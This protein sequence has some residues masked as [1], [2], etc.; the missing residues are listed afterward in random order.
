[1]QL[2]KALF[3]ILRLGTTLE[4]QGFISALVSDA[5]D[6]DTRSV[7]ASRRPGLTRSSSV[8]VR[9]VRALEI[10]VRGD[11]ERQ[12]AIRSRD[13]VRQPRFDQTVWC[14]EIESDR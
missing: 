3:W 10:R 2:G 4:C 13:C 5:Q 6:G 1:M 9:T 11:I 8:R 14:T 12:L 7:H